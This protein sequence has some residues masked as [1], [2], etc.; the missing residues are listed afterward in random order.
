[1]KFVAFLILGASLGCYAAPES[2]V[3]G[4]KDGTV[5]QAVFKNG[6]YIFRVCTEP[7][8]I[9][10]SV[11]CEDYDREKVYKS[12]AHLYANLVSGLEESDYYYDLKRNVELKKERA[13]AVEFSRKYGVDKKEEIKELDY[14]IEVHNARLKK[15]YGITDAQTELNNISARINGFVAGVE[16]PQEIVKKDE[17]S[18]NIFSE[19][20]YGDIVW[21]SDAENVCRKKFPKPSRKPKAVMASIL[22]QISEKAPVVTEKLKEKKSFE[23]ELSEPMSLG[24]DG[25]SLKIYKVKYD[26]KNYKYQNTVIY[27]DKD[28]KRYIQVYDKYSSIDDDYHFNQNQDIIKDFWYN[29]HKACF[30]D[31]EK[32]EKIEKDFQECVKKEELTSSVK[33]MKY[34]E[35][36]IKEG[37]FKLNPKAAPVNNSQ[38]SSGKAVGEKSQPAPK[39]SSN[40]SKQ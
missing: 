12:R 6:Q 23:I 34:Y 37:P 9:K 7:E 30:F 5:H 25:C 26:D 20:L 33:E 8:K 17:L 18:E 14:E 36:I 22:S 2:I 16:S 21:K 35:D 38:R 28:L 24:K 1:M 40:S 10:P 3:I 32:E 19:L 27:L 29:E 11:P 15:D 13:A 4:Q 39:K 31:L